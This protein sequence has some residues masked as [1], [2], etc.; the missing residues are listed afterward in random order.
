MSLPPHVAAEVRRI[1]DG[2][3]RRLLADEM[4]RDPVAPTPGGDLGPVHD[5]A[6]QGTASVEGQT[7]PNPSRP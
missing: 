5:G 7:A 3:A 6:D 1:L 2:E 4:D